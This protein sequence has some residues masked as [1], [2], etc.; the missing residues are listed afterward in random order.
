MVAVRKQ[1]PP[2]AG[3]AAIRP[4]LVGFMIVADGVTVA[5]LAIVRP[6]HWFAPFLGFGIVLI[7]LVGFEVWAIGHR[8][9][10]G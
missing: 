7:G 4:V 5:A 9:D 1:G 2:Q 8:Y 3:W 10:D 6:E